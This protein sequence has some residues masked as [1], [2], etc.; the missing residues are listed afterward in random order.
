MKTL[1]EFNVFLDQQL[2]DELRSMEAQRVTGRNWMRRMWIVTLVPF[3]IFVFFLV[4]YSLQ[5]SRDAAAGQATESGNPVFMIIGLVV[6]FSLGGYAISYF[7][8][9]QKG[10]NEAAD[11]QHDFK[12]RIVKP[13]IR[14]IDPTFTYQPINHASYEEFTESGLFAKK[15]YGMTGNDQVYGKLGDM[16]F[17]CC[18][19]TVTYT[20]TITVRGQA[21]DTVFRGSYFIGQ[22]PRYFSTPVYILSRG[23]G[24]ERLLSNA[25]ADNDFIETWNLGKKVL[26]DDAAFNKLFMVYAPDAI[27]AQQ[28]LTPALMGKIISLQ[29]RTSAK[30]Y[31]SFFNNR[32]YIGIGH[33]MD[34]FETTLNKSLQDKKMLQNFYLDFTTVLQLA[35]DLKGNLPIWTSHAFSR[36]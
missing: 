31:L 28:L 8:M 36:S 27:E 25:A 33:G 16:N 23:S 3:A 9:K 34:Y 14:F 17:Q 15:G 7:M 24:M 5:S 21:P 22:F 12:N 26:P 1:E 11:Y 6:L 32:V 18:D 10:G 4:R 29:E 20:P 13:L 19:L 35:E 2:A 30:L